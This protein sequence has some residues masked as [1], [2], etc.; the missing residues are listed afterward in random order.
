[1]MRDSGVLRNALPEPAPAGRRTSPDA[2]IR[3]PS[4]SRWALPPPRIARHLCTPL[5][6]GPRIDR[7]PDGLLE[8]AEF[9]R[10]LMG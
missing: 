1:M 4:W 7:V 6:L 10:H 5:V 9:V 8:G 3:L 2:C